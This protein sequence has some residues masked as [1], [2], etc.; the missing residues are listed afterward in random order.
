MGAVAW[1]KPIATGFQGIPA[2]IA[3]L[4][5]R[6]DSTLLSAPLSKQIRIIRRIFMRNIQIIRIIG[7]AVLITVAGFASISVAQVTAQNSRAEDDNFQPLNYP[8]AVC[9][10]VQAPA[11]NKLLARVYAIGVQTYRWNGS[12]WVFVEPVATL[13]NDPSHH[14]KAGIHYAGPTWEAN[15]G[16]KVV[17]ARLASC[18]A[19][20][21][22]IPWLLL[23]TTSTEGTGIL[24]LVTYIQRINT[25]GGLAPAAPGAS[26][27]AVAEVPYTAEYYFYRAKN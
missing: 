24:S 7:L 21:N 20:P 4:I 17:A 6:Q 9:D 19:D 26:I 16:A 25:V 1:E 27:G 3:G 13:Y 22:A 11:G 14:D 15:N 23:Q 8:S 5:W 10:T 18:T 12:S 2:S